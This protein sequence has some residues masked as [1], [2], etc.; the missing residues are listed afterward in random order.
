MAGPVPFG[1]GQC[2]PCRI[3]K[4]RLWTWRMFYE[5]QQHEQSCFVTLTYNQEHV[6]ADGSLVPDHP[7]D[8]LKRLRR[9]IEPRRLRY[10]AVGEY[11]DVS[12]RPHYHAILFGVGQTDAKHV[13]QSWPYG[14]TLVGEF[15]QYTA[16]YV[17]GYVVKKLT[18]ADDPRLKGRYPEFAR[19]SLKPG[20]GAD[21][22]Q[23]IANQLHTDAGLNHLSN[24]GDVPLFLT[25]GGKQIPLGR[26]LRQKLREEM[27]MP[28][29]MTDEAKK[30]T[31][32]ARS[33][34]MRALYPD[35]K[36]L[37]EGLGSFVTKEGLKA[38][39]KG[40]IASVEARDK[41]KQSK[42]GKTL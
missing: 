1:C 26:Y 9:R 11:G 17:A 27:G 40:S 25:V 32:L 7:K 20:I 10:F 13:E 5:S 19:M 15:N 4:R 24:T 2:L 35:K 29:W 41:I 8:W 28:K 34:E 30:Q 3:Q 21:A 39:W 31:S 23:L 12:Q 38:H 14:F 36:L 16:Q 22:M 37:E 42:K 33:Q 18:K 6:P